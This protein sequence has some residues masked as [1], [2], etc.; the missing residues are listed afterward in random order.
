MVYPTYWETIS[1]VPAALPNTHA[2]IANLGLIFRKTLS[3]LT[4]AFL[5]PCL[6]MLP[7]SVCHL[8]VSLASIAHKYSLSKHLFLPQAHTLPPHHTLPESVVLQPMHRGLSWG[9]LK[10]DL[11]WEKKKNKTCSGVP[12]QR[13]WSNW[14]EYWG[15]SL[16]AP[17]VILL[18]S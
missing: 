11:L 15:F 10:K 18:C 8:S 6:P 3:Y 9:S 4:A 12:A 1:S 13:F 17:W 7:T 14:C 5:A 16:S 2:W